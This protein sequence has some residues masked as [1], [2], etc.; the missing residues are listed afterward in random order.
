MMV[1]IAE[2]LTGESSTHVECHMEVKDGL[3]LVKFFQFW[4]DESAEWPSKIE[5]LAHGV[6]ENVVWAVVAD[7][8]TRGYHMVN[9]LQADLRSIP[10]E[11]Q[12]V[13]D[14]YKPK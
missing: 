12:K 13:F 2:S 11:A 7:T 1:Q 14:H 6:T 10:I 4:L 9:F 3:D 8:T 5:T